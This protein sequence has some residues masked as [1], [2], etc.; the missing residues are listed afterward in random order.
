M[1]FPMDVQMKNYPG[2]K[3]ESGKTPNTPMVRIFLSLDFMKKKTQ[4][5]CSLKVSKVVKKL[6]ISFIKL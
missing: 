3:P 5:E 2:E 6:K 1:A 4:N